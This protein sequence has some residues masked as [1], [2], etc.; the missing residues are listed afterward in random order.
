MEEQTSPPAEEKT[1]EAAAAPE[2][3][4]ISVAQRKKMRDQQKQ[5]ASMFQ[6]FNEKQ[7]VQRQKLREEAN[8]M[9]THAW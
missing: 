6:K 3:P 2:A 8:R 4:K 1:A 5:L 9:P 7:A